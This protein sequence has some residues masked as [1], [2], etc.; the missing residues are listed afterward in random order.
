MIFMKCQAVCLE[1]KN[2][3]NRVASIGGMIEINNIP[4][5]GTLFTIDFNVE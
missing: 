2:L 1:L 3:K 5:K 4:D